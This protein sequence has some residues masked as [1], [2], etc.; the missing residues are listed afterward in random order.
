MSS[1]MSNAQYDQFHRPDTTRSALYCL[2]CMTFDFHDLVPEK[3]IEPF[4]DQKNGKRHMKMF[5]ICPFCDGRL[6]SRRVNYKQK[7]EEDSLR[8]H[9]F[10]EDA[11]RLNTDSVIRVMNTP[12]GELRLH[13]S[14]HSYFSPMAILNGKPSPAI[15]RLVDEALSSADRANYLMNEEAN[16][17]QWPNKTPKML[18]IIQ[19]LEDDIERTVRDVDEAVEKSHHELNTDYIQMAAFMGQL[20]VMIQDI[21]LD[22]NPVPMVDMT[23]MSMQAA[24]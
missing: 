9:Q 4:E 12:W 13:I 5:D 2:E 15:K 18:E 16:L 3:R 23:V 21:H 14:R 24:A 17:R 7:Q 19:C 20:S 10:Q 6:V 11:K 1:T 22:P 8:K